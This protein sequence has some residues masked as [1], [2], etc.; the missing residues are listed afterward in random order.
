[1][2]YGKTTN[3]KYTPMEIGEL[4]SN[5]TKNHYRDT[6]RL[7]NTEEKNGVE[8]YSISNSTAECRDEQHLS[9]DI[10]KASRRNFAKTVRSRDDNKWKDFV[11]EQITPDWNIM[12]DPYIRNMK[13]DLFKLLMN[14][15]GA[16]GEEPLINTTGGSVYLP[17]RLPYYETIATKEEELSELYIIDFINKVTVEQE[18]PLYRGTMKYQKVLK[19][20]DIDHNRVSLRKIKALGDNKNEVEKHYLKLSDVNSIRMIRLQYRA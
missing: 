5:P 1:M 2:H 18:N 13:I 6:I 9:M 12:P 19:I 17:F 7:L 14:I 11:F 8:A 20:E 10:G 3:D 16:D 4:L 15:A